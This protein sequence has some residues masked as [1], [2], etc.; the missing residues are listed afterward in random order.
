MKFKTE[1]S[2]D[3]AMIGIWDADASSGEIPFKRLMDELSKDGKEGKLLR[4][5][6]GADGGYSICVVSTQEELR[7]FRLDAYAKIEHV[8]FLKSESGA[9][10]A[11]GLEDY[12]NG[13]PQITSKDDLI[14]LEPGTFRVHAYVHSET[15]E[16]ISKQVEAKTGVDD[17][18]YYQYR[19]NGFGIAI[20]VI[21]IGAVLAFFWS[22]WALLPAM[23][24][25]SGVLIYFSRL[26]SSDARIQRVDQAFRIYENAHPTLIFYFESVPEIGVSRGFFH[27]DEV[28]EQRG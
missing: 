2:T 10:I 5:D 26:N 12:R 3:I 1:A 19:N 17:L 11:G 4:V 21:G 22:W 23:L 9:F 13:T 14:K 7:T 27:L 15:E 25:A 24:M 16:Q 20:G 18:R 28:P 6:T 8:F